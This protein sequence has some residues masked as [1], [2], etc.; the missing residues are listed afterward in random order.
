MAGRGFVFSSTELANANSLMG[1]DG[2]DAG[3]MTLVLSGVYHNSVVA[4]AVFCGIPVAMLFVF[5]YGSV[6]WRFFRSIMRMD[7]PDWRLLGVSLLGFTVAITGQMLMNGAGNT[8]LV[9]CACLGVM[10]GMICRMGKLKNTLCVR[11][12]KSEFRIQNAEV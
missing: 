1:F 3:Q 8:F 9:V 6:L 7:R 2:L 11:T 4:L 10:N 5:G 12:K